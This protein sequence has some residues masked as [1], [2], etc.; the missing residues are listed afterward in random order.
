M[1]SQPRAGENRPDLVVQRGDRQYVVEIKISPE[2][3]RDRLIPILA[4]G[5][6]QAK[7]VAAKVSQ[8]AAP[9][10][11]I[12]VPRLSES[13][14][15]DLQSF[16]AQ[17]APDVSIGIIDSE[18]SRIFAGPDLQELSKMSFSL[19]PS[20]ARSLPLIPA[21]A[22]HLFSDLN[23]WM[24]KVLLSPRISGD[25]LEAPRGRIGGA[26]ELAKVAGVSVMS[27]FRCVKSL[28]AHGFVDN[29]ARILRLINVEAL[30]AQW[31]AARHKPIRE[32]PM[33]WLI[34]GDPERQLRDAI[35]SYLDRNNSAAIP[36]RHHG[37]R[38]LPYP[39]V[40]LG[41]F[42]AAEALGF[43]FVHGVAPH[44]YLERVDQRA[45]EPL[46]LVAAQSGQRAD[47]LVRVPSFR[48]AVFRGTVSREGI[49]VSDV[50]QVW[51]D[52]AD[53]PARGA[54]QA[55]EIWRRV[56]VQLLKAE[57]L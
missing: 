32:L 33:R 25:L 10:V 46:G 53:H 47:V 21:P 51:L 23:Q 28:K 5:I 52:V 6:L 4:Q 2:A 44:L 11:V 42:A 48:E 27:A 37:E 7:A 12:G 39:R 22:L 31:R 19:P 16:A 18:G 41:L 50:L 57:P 29:H 55:E 3:R 14:F 45:L 38:G 49:P 36:G 1:V 20:G 26:S 40:C 43:G 30:L 9:L 24:I 17:V 13:L 15:D 54:S 34:P 56:L 35:R 8:S